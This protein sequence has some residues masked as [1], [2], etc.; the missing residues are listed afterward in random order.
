MTGRRARTD[1]RTGYLYF[2][3]GVSTRRFHLTGR[4]PVEGTREFGL[5]TALDSRTNKQAWQKEVPY[6]AGFGSGVL[7]TAGGLLFHGGTDGYFR[8][9]DSRTGDEVWRFQTGFGADAPAAVYEIDGEE[10]VTIAAGGSRDGLRE[11]REI[12]LGLQARRTLESAE[13]A[14]RPADRRAA[15]RK[16]TSWW[17]ARLVEDGAGSSR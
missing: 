6:L 9:F 17:R 13:R 11:A 2:T 14:A 7:A 10:Y 12:S 3:V 1:P 15:R 5:I 8:A 4:T 16:G